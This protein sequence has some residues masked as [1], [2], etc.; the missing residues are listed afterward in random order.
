MNLKIC[1]ALVGLALFTASGTAEA[2]RAVLEDPQPVKFGCEL[3]MKTVQKGLKEAFAGRKWT[4]KW[5]SNGRL[6]GK[7]IVRN[8]H[9]LVV[10]VKYNT[11]QF[12]INYKNSNNLKYRVKDGVQTIHPNANKWIMNVNNDA[13][14]ILSSKCR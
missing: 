6:V 8:K 11:R 7:I 5:V 9:T 4:T 13:T 3:A 10:E 2:R 1:F 14:S 12:D